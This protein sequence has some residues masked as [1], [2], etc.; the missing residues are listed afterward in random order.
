MK[1]ETSYLAAALALFVLSTASLRAT[2]TLEIQFE[3]GTIPDGALA[4]IVA[5]TAEDGFLPMTET[6]VSG[7]VLSV[8]SA[9]GGGDDTIIAFF[10]ASS[11][12]EWTS[13]TGIAE[14]LPSLDYDSLGISEGTP[15]AIYVFP[16][17]TAPGAL[18]ILGDRYVVYR[19]SNT[20]GSGGSIPFSAPPDPGVYAVAALTAENGGTF[21]PEALVSGETYETG[22]V[23]ATGGGGP[24]DIGNSRHDAFLLTQGIQP[25][26]L[27]AGDLDFFRFVLTEPSVLLAGL[28]SAILA[29]AWIFDEQGNVIYSPD[30]SS[31]FDFEEILQPGTY[32]LAL[33]GE[34]P[35]ETGNYSL[36]LA[37]RGIILAK[38]DI[39]VG[40]SPSKQ[41]GAK[42]YNSSGARQQF[43]AKSKQGRKVRSFFT[44]GNAGDLDGTLGIRGSAGNRFYR[45]KY[46]SIGGAGNVTASIRRG[47]YLSSYSPSQSVLYR[48]DLK[49]TRDGKS[50]GKSGSFKIDSSGEGGVDT[51]K[52]KVKYIRK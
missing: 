50:R 28:N 47:G 42:I 11:G 5:D 39:T 29:Q 51:G 9:F 24:G 31:L 15:L 21:D 1:H 14:S 32:F 7:T 46:V 26:H 27:T 25:G 4:A 49:P 20:G 19:N 23:G 52:I 10:N 38:P 13:G 43:T 40:G 2:V 8:G 36:S 12:S 41:K 45:L 44:V 17:M 16:D 18:F 22:N 3:D 34:N 33:L 30:G 37:S 6:S 48:L 35:S